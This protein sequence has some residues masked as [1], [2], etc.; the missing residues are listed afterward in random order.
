MK[1]IKE[2]VENGEISIS[3]ANE[4]AKLDEAEQE[5]LAGAD[6]SSIKHKDIKNEVT[7]KTVK[8]T[9]KASPD[10]Q[11]VDTYINIEDEDENEDTEPD[12]IEHDHETEEKVD[13]YINFSKSDNNISE[14]TLESFIYKNYYELESILTDCMA[15]NDNEEEI[16][17]LTEFHELL[18]AAKEAER[19]KKRLGM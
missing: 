10:K 15:Y 16:A 7:A 17:L 6:L 18:Y 8:K 12:E 5:K 2:A 1:L 14:N 13:T 11:K 4:I 3:T 9:D 19:K